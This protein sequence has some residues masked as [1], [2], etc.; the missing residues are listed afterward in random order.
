VSEWVGVTEEG[1]DG[2]V[3]ED[4][5]TQNFFCKKDFARKK[6]HDIFAFFEV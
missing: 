5:F 6:K 4:F 2:G 1:N 3:V